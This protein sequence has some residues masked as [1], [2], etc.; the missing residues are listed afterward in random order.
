MKAIADTGGTV[1]ITNVPAFLGG[2]GC[3]DAMLDHLDHAVGV[4][5]AEHVTIGTDRPYVGVQTQ[6]ENAKVPARNGTQRRRWEALWWED[7][8]VH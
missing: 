8:P 5:G 2:S 6:D 3:I 1:G 7:D 4:V